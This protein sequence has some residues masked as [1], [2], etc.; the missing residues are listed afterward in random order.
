MKPNIEDIL[1]RAQGIR[2]S[3]TEKSLL[4]S[5]IMR[6]IETLPAPTIPSSVGPTRSPFFGHLM[7]GRAMY[8]Y[9][10]SFALA[11]LFVCV[12]VGT[13]YAAQ[14]AL[15]GDP[16]YA[17]K[18]ALNENVESALA[19]GP[20]AAAKVSAKHALT[21]LK[22]VES[23]SEKGSLD[24]TTTE[25]LRERFSEELG[26]TQAS[27]RSVRDAGDTKDADD[28]HIELQHRLREHHGRVRQFADLS[29]TTNPALSDLQK[30]IEREFDDAPGNSGD[31]DIKNNTSHM[32]K[33]NGSKDLIPNV[34]DNEKGSEKDHARVSPED[35]GD[36]AQQ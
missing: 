10:M 25:Q 32:Q 14:G 9:R 18:I 29:S 33:S 3:D 19:I 8:A 17:V 20:A 23:L 15:P 26:A 12:G 24:A 30:S 34:N 36:I 16:L 13:S 4:L 31:T 28:I 35:A 27:L 5:N 6:D 22:E 2:L 21:R 11:A 7:F 1:K